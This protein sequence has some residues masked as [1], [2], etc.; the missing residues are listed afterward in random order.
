M[1]GISLPGEPAVS[2]RGEDGE[3]FR[4]LV[5]PYRRELQVHCYRILGSVQDAEDVLQE[6]L[7]AAWRGIDGF[8]E[9]ASVRTWLYRIATNRCLNA[10]R[11]SARRPHERAAYQLEVALPEPSRRREEP[12]WLEPY[13]DVLL[14]EIA[15]HLPGPEARYEVRESVSLAFLVALQ[16]LPPRQRA[17]LVLRD[18]LGFRAAEVASMLDTTENA[19]TSA[20]RRARGALAHVLPGPDRESAPLPDSPQERRVVAD[21][22]RAFEAGDVDAIVAM[23]TDDAWLTMP[24]LPLEYQG[25]DAIRHFLATVALRRCRREMLVPTRANG[26]PAFGCYVRDPRTP[27][28]HAHGLLVLTLT[29]DRIIAL[30]RFHDNSLLTGFG[31]PRSLRVNRKSDGTPEEEER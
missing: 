27:I 15:D 3:K 9:R 17:V 18:V 24:P 10:L 19:V 29:G 16:R 11:S 25:R 6:T 4:R 5:E 31:L 7:L 2:A 1:Q 30:T 23:L 8:E 12:S 13:P 21:F 28:L 26:Q 22:T 14:D 20:L